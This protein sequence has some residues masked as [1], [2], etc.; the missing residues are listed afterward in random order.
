EGWFM[1]NVVNS[2]KYLQTVYSFL[3]LDLADFSYSIGKS[4]NDAALRVGVNTVVLNSADYGSYQA[5]KR[6]ISGEIFCSSGFVIP[7][8]T[9]SETDNSLVNWE[10]LDG[11][12]SKLP[13][14]TL[15][16]AV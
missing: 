10:T 1:E 16:S 13:P 3:D 15:K 4:P 7:K 9:H 12:M 2:R 8:P 5:R 11:L 6:S 14:P